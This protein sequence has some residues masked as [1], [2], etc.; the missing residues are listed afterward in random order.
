MA[1]PALVESLPIAD[2]GLQ[3]ADFSGGHRRLA[4]WSSRL[5]ITNFTS[6][7]LFSFARLKTPA[8]RRLVLKFINLAFDRSLPN[9]SEQMSNSQPANHAAVRQTIER[10]SLWMH[11]AVRRRELY[12]GRPR[13]FCE[14]V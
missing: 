3:I 4:C 10:D 9:D 8:A 1:K 2:D 12:G 6:E 5:A 11:S 13:A 7:T 14:L